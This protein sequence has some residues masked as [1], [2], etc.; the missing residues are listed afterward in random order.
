MGEG[1]RRGIRLTGIILWEAGSM[2]FYCVIYGLRLGSIPKSNE[3][4]IIY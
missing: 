2:Y 1:G 3:T 4:D